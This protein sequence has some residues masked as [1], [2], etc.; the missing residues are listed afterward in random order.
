MAGQAYFLSFRTGHPIP[1][2]ISLSRE[3]VY[4]YLWAFLT[5]LVLWLARKY[6]IDSSRWHIHA[7]LHLGIS[8]ALATAHKICYYLITTM[9]D[10]A[11]ESAFSFSRITTLMW[12]YLDYGMLLYWF[13]LALH[14]VAEYYGRFKE[15]EVRASQ[16]ETQLTRAQ[17]DTLKMQLQPHFLFNTLN[18]VSVLIHHDPDAA[19]KMIGKLADLLRLALNNDAAQEISLRQ[20]LVFLQSF[21]E[22]EKTRLKDR[23]RVN[24]DI[25]ADALDAAVP[26]LI[27]QP[28]VENALRH[29]VA[30]RQGTAIVE[31]TAGR[32]NGALRLQVKD[33]G[34]GFANLQPAKEGIGLS[35]TRARLH[36]LYGA[37]HS[38]EISNAPTGGAVTTIIIPFSP[39]LRTGYEPPD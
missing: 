33:N 3:L 32:K 28:L 14:Q 9:A 2:G 27:L 39:A 22:I 11:P 19:R 29:G 16:L 37:R 8:F 34:P 5:P 36:R 26:N 12:S 6:P 10:G 35:N 23:L 20:E 15:K 4:A 7:V 18:A 17:L 24:I 1:W 25:A 38:F 21:L 31:I 30:E 13:L